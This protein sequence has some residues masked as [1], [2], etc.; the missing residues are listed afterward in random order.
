MKRE[1]GERRVDARLVPCIGGI[2]VEDALDTISAGQNMSQNKA[3]EKGI[4]SQS[5]CHLCSAIR[6]DGVCDKWGKE[7]ENVIIF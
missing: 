7:M 6:K 3:V 5:R 1:K 2:K 4:N